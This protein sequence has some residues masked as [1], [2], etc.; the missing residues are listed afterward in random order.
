MRVFSTLV[1][2]PEENKSLYEKLHKKIRA[3]MRFS[4]VWVAKVEPAYTT[5]KI[6]DVEFENPWR[7]G[8][9]LFVFTSYYEAKKVQLGGICHLGVRFN[10][11]WRIFGVRF[12]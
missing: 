6:F 12:T 5:P 11:N 1:S 7:S 2:R 9:G 4:C 10:N 8:V 3:C